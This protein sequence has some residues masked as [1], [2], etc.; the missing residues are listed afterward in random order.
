M[1]YLRIAQPETL[2]GPGKVRRV[3]GQEQ[4]VV[5]PHQN[6]GENI[7][8]EANRCLP[9]SA[10]EKVPVSII[11]KNTPR[12]IAPGQDMIV[13]P[14]ILYPPRP[15]QTPSPPSFSLNPYHILIHN[16]KCDPI[17]DCGSFDGPPRDHNVPV[18]NAALGINTAHLPILGGVYYW[19]EE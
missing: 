6:K 14:S 2:H 5:V 15:C 1:A 17:N 19:Q 11:E 7:H 18:P 8:L 13:S 16:S 10:Q 4:M 12:F 3:G 9:K